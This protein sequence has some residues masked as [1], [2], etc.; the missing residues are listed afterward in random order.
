MA[1]NSELAICLKP[2]E[3]SLWDMVKPSKRKGKYFG[4]GL[5]PGSIIYS[6]C[7]FG[8]VIKFSCLSFLMCSVELAI[9][10][11]IGLRGFKQIVHFSYSEQ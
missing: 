5:Y 8:E 10:A 6:L 1:M 3:G 7:D 11:N 9:I 4:L 2:H